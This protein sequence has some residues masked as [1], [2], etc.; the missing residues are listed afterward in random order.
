[1]LPGIIRIL[2][3]RD[4]GM[5]IEHAIRILCIDTDIVDPAWVETSNRGASRLV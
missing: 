5:S 4:V 2:I 1:M 3:E